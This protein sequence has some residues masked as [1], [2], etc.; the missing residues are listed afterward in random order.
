MAPHRPRCTI[1]G[2]MDSLL[3]T[4][5]GLSIDPTDL[6][7]SD[8]RLEDIS[9]ALSMLCRGCGHIRYFY[10]VA[11]HC[12]NCSFEAEARGWSK[13]LQLAC[14]LHDASEAYAS[15]IVS[16]V[17]PLVAGY[18]QIE[19]DVQSA[20]WEHYGLAD[21]TPEECAQIKDVDTT[22]FTNEFHH[23]M[24]AWTGEPPRPMSSVPNLDERTHDE[25]QAEFEA[26]VAELME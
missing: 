20:I 3:H 26:R 17:K 2:R 18:R 25:V 10:S 4:Y 12:L 11:Q 24:P 6:R 14:L 21:L 22:L 13:R 1:M 19:A 9:H 15:D 8:I 5:T 7:A 16:P 23:M